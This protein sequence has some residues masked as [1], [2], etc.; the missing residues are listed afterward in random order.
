MWPRAYPAANEQAS[1]GREQKENQGSCT[2]SAVGTRVGHRG[3]QSSFGLLAVLAQRC[4]NTT[5]HNTTR[6]YGAPGSSMR[7]CLLNLGWEKTPL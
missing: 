1:D 2:Q 5:Q 4:C 7:A 6:G 3:R